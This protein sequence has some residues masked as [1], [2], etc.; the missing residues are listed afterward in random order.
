MEEV[1]GCRP[2]SRSSGPPFSLDVRGSP[3]RWYGP[4]EAC[5]DKSWRLPD[6]EQV[7]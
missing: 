2:T 6:I 4:T 1:I 3:F 7:K 5:Y